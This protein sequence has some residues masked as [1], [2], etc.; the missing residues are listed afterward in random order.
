MADGGNILFVLYCMNGVG[1]IRIAQRFE[2]GHRKRRVRVAEL[3]PG[4][5][6]RT[7]L[8]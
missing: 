7:R 2:R 4:E 3:P 6:T 1:E 8:E 5:R